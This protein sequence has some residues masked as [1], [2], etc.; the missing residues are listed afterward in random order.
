MTPGLKLSFNTNLLLAS[1]F[2]QQSICRFCHMSTRAILIPFS[3]SRPLKTGQY[4]P[5]RLG[6]EGGSHFL[7]PLGVFANH[8]KWPF[9]RDFMLVNMDRVHE[10]SGRGWRTPEDEVGVTIATTIP[11]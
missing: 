8:T 1:I 11:Q 6:D 7:A 4:L 3:R 9:K 2:Y 10:F 5:R